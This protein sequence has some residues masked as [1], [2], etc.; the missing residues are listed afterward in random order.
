MLADSGVQTY[1][2]SSNNWDCLETFSIGG[3]TFSTRGTPPVK[4]GILRN[5][6]GSEVATCT[7]TILCGTDNTGPIAT[8]ISGAWD[9]AEVVV[10]RV[11][12]G[13]SLVRFRGYVADVRPTSTSVEV[14]AKSILL[15]LKKKVPGRQY[16]TLCPYIRG[17]ADCGAGACTDHTATTCTT[18]NFGGFATIPPET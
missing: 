7:F 8:A 3:E 16:G 4:R 11:F 6:L 2:N 17:D 14:S 13:A 12:A 18:G 10:T 5:T 9:G 15:E 1:L